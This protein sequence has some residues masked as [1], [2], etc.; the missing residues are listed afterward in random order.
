M[1]PKRRK[2]SSRS[3]KKAEQTSMEEIQHV[4]AEFVR[5]QQQPQPGSG[6]T[7][8]NPIH[9]QPNPRPTSSIY[10]RPVNY[11]NQGGTADTNVGNDTS[12]IDQWLHPALQRASRSISSMT[13]FGGLLRRFEAPTPEADG[14]TSP[15]A[16]ASATPRRQGGSAAAVRRSQDSRRTSEGRR[17][18]EGGRSLEARQR[19]QQARQPRAHVP[20]AATYECLCPE[21]DRRWRIFNIVF[22]VISIVIVIMLSLAMCLALGAFNHNKDSKQSPD[23]GGVTVPSISFLTTSSSLITYDIGTEHSSPTGVTSISYD[24]TASPPK[25]SSF[26]SSSP[27][28]SSSSASSSEPPAIIATKT[29]YLPAPPPPPPPEPTT[30]TT[31]SEELTTTIYSPVTTIYVSWDV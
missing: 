18:R 7:N 6:L 23:S 12:A 21:C 14:Q 25:S 26:S 24:M 13:S 27:L 11:E 30:H 15:R 31:T 3:N 10:S 4:S 2:R 16:S 9:H 5:P 20:G 28:R 22:V 29:V 17:N 8:N 1:A 19:T